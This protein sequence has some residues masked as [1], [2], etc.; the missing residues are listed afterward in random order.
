MKSEDDSL[1]VDIKTIFEY[2]TATNNNNNRDETA[3][4]GKF[5]RFTMINR[6]KRAM[7]STRQT[8]P[9]HGLII[10]FL[11]LL[12]E[13]VGQQK[14]QTLIY[15]DGLAQAAAESTDTLSN[16]GERQLSSR[17]DL[18]RSRAGGEGASHNHT[19]HTGEK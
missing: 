10:K 13:Q 8:A 18:M 2:S 11:L 15:S 1:E 3:G 4:A 17:S 19:A 5:R 7:K 9:Q 16:S 14:L 12:F 6:I